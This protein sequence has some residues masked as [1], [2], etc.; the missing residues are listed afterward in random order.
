MRRVAIS[1]GPLPVYCTWDRPWV[2]DDGSE[3]CADAEQHDRLMEG[4]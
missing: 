1:A 3:L 2:K 4:F